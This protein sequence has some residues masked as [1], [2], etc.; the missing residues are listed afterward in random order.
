MERKENTTQR[1]ELKHVIFGKRFSDTKEE[2]EDSF[3]GEIAMIES[4]E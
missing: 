4:F 2:R 3:V 1:R